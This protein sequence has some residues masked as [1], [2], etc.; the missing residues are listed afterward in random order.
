M[1]KSYK[2]FIG[3]LYNAHKVKPLH[4]MLPKTSAYVKSYDWQTKWMCFLTEDE[5]LLKKYNAIWD[6]FS[7]EDFDSKPVYNK[8]FWKL[9]ENPMVMKLQLFM[10]KEFLR[11][12]LI[13]PV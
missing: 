8:S 10:L 9:K 13:I 2:Y 3:Y 4:I 1:K 11:Q 5:D 7:A 6:K 12:T